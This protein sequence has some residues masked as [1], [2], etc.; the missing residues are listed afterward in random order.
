MQLFPG[1][2]RDYFLFVQHQDSEIMRLAPVDT[3]DENKQ[4]WEMSVADIRILVCVWM[5]V[6]LNN[7]LHR[8]AF[9][10]FALSSTPKYCCLPK[11]TPA[12]QPNNKISKACFDLAVNLFYL[13]SLF[14]NTLTSTLF[15]GEKVASASLPK[16]NEH[17][18]LHLTK[19]LKVSHLLLALCHCI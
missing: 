6:Y 2:E 5:W 17:L 1:E 18:Y 11:Y 16:E 3:N 12:K 9:L 15:A 4:K 13:L 10:S 8:V 7:E 14:I 19:L